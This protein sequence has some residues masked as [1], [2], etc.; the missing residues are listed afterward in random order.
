MTSY[1]L[2]DGYKPASQSVHYIQLPSVFPIAE[3][4]FNFNHIQSLT[5]IITGNVDLALDVRMA[6][7]QDP[8]IPLPPQSNATFDPLMLSYVFEYTQKTLHS[9]INASSRLDNNNAI[10]R[11]DTP[12]D[13]QFP[14]V[15]GMQASLMLPMH[16]DWPLDLDVRVACGAVQVN[17]LNE[18]LVLNR[19]TFMANAG[20]INVAGIRAKSAVLHTNTGSVQATV[21]ATDFIDFQTNAGWISAVAH[22][23]YAPG[24]PSRH[25][26]IKANAGP[27]SGAIRGYKDLT[28][29]TDA[30]AISLDLQP[31]P[32]LTSSTLTKSDAGMTTLVFDEGF[33][34]G[35]YAEAFGRATVTGSRVHA[36]RGLQHGRRSSQWFPF[37]GKAIVTGHVGDGGANHVRSVV[38]VGS[39]SLDFK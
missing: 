29:L 14:D 12:S 39:V 16:L 19:V 9:S 18:S 32:L 8:P 3:G 4:L 26:L 30:G 7:S 5:I 34:G 33:N 24:L 1:F 15:L 23:D 28:V 6:P 25:S 20:L 22:L 38:Q 27:V 10:I 21:N 35:F 31:S 36:D 17:A 2:I 11:I 37:P 13:I